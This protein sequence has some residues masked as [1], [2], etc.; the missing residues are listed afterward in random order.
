[1]SNRLSLVLVQ[2]AFCGDKGICLCARMK[3]YSPG[4]Y[5]NILDFFFFFTKSFFTF[6]FLNERG[7]EFCILF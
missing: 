7:A 1:M 4:S 6:S 5:E 3:I 2:V